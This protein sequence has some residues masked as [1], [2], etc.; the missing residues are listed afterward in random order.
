MLRLQEYEKAMDDL[1][2]AKQLDPD[3]QAVRTKLVL[4][5]EKNKALNAKYAQAMKKFFS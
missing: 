4:L 5:D 3:N 1:Q 2:R